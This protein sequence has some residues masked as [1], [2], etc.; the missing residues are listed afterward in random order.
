VQL[1]LPWVIQPNLLRAFHKIQFQ[2]AFLRAVLNGRDSIQYA[3]EP[4]HSH[5][6]TLGKAKTA[7]AEKQLRKAIR[8]DAKYAVAWVTL[9]Q[10][11]TGKKQT[12]EA[13]QACLQASTAAPRY[14]PAYL[15]LA[16]IAARAHAWNEVLR[17]SDRA[18][19]L[20]PAQD[21]LADEYNAAA[22]LNLHH[23]TEAE[24]SGLRAVDIDKNHREPRTLFVLAQIYEAKGDTAKRNQLAA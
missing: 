24:K 1:L 19:E 14:I 16:D 10:V 8:T 12:D 23:L 15:C 5:L 3:K 9:G 17:F 22:H 13:Q 11:L 4:K 6:G 2:I 18:L 21:F 20:D 7:D